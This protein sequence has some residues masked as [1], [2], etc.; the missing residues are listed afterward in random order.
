M[1]LRIAIL[2]AVACHAAVGQTAAPD[3]LPAVTVGAG[4]S[5]NRGTTSPLAENTSVALRIKD[6]SWYSWTMA[7]TAL[8]PPV[9]GTGPRLST[10]T[11][12][13]AYVA[14]QSAT[15][16]VA[17]VLIVQAGLTATALATSATFNGNVGVAVRLGKNSAFRVMPYAGGQTGG[18]TPVGAFVMQPGVMLLYGFG[19]K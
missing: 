11:T 1:T 8:S 10:I 4:M 19:G 5:W 16:R 2:A 9:K 13:A 7:A 12:G 15:G 3:A 6:T 17:L 14:A 18:G